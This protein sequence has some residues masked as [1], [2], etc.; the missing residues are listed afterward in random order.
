[1]SF[2][3]VHSRQ[4]LP[5]AYRADKSD[6]EMTSFVTLID[7][8]R[9]R[10]MAPRANERPTDCTKGHRLKRFPRAAEKLNCH[11]IKTNPFQPRFASCSRFRSGISRPAADFNEVPATA[12]ALVFTTPLHKAVDGRMQANDKVTR[13]RKVKD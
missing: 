4:V 7:V 13:R 9:G 2:C 12:D 3:R 8:Y 1:M 5:L 11:C 10:L 6:G